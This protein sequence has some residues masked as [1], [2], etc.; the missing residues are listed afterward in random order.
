ME[1]NDIRTCKKC[2]EEKPLTN[3]PKIK[4]GTNG[5][6]YRGHTCRK[7]R[8]QPAD[9]E[10]QRRFRASKPLNMIVNAAR[11]RA[12]GEGKECT[13]TPTDVQC[14]WDDQQGRCAL[15]GI[16][17]ILGRGDGTHRTPPYKASL[18]RI[19]AGGDYVPGNVRLVAWAVNR[20]LGEY[21]QEL[22]LDWANRL[23]AHQWLQVG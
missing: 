21:G 20:A 19:E 10:R 12:R 14:L 16:P 2:S 8:K 23:V 17:M 3:Y 5:K 15:T 18:D 13:I 22:L 9:S 6:L 7:C 11:T 4:S 1:N